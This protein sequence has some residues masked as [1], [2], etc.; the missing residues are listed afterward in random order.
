M[1]ATELPSAFNDFIAGTDGVVA[2]SFVKATEDIVLNIEIPHP[3]I[4]DKE[5]ITFAINGTSYDKDGF[6]VKP[7]V[8]S[9]PF[10]DIH[11]KRNNSA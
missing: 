8:E 6:I 5:K 10:Y 4:V 3:F 1:L 11:V 9:V 7:E 2:M